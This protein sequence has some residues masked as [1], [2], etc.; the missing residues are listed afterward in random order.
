[1]PTLL[2]AETLRDSRIRAWSVCIP[3]TVVSVLLPW[4]HRPHLPDPMPVHFDLSG[5]A[6]RW[7]PRDAACW[8]QS[9][10]ALL[11]AVLLLLITAALPRVPARWVNIPHRNVWLSPERRA[12]TLRVLTTFLAWT[13][14]GVQA[15]F[16]AF[17][18]LARRHALSPA[19]PITRSFWMLIGLFLLFIGVSSLLLYRHFLILPPD[20]RSTES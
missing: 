15:L 17:W 2:P 16:I 4:L 11:I 6:D 9:L 3:L 13:L 10:S 7:L 5:M 19:V 1:M 8:H 12:A 14:A 18:S 20:H